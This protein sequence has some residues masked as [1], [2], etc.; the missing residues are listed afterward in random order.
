MLYFILFL[1]G[2]GIGSFLNVVT[3]RYNEDGW[4]AGRHLGG[5][6]RC[7]HCGKTLA[8]YEL[9]PLLSFIIQGAKCRSCGAPLSWQYPLVELL[10]ALIFVF[11]PYQLAILGPSLIW[12]LVF[13]SLLT[14]AVI[15]FR[16]YMVP[17]EVTAFL[18]VLGI[19]WTAFFAGG[20]FIGEHAEFFGLQGNVW[21]NHIFAAFLGAALIALIFFGTKGKAIGFGDVKLFG[22]LGLLFG[23]PDIVLVFFLSFIVG[24]LFSVPLLIRRLKGMKDFVPFAPFI[25]V[26][27]LIIF[28]AGDV[29]MNWYF[30]LLGLS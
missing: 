22:A 3:L 4:V 14:I 13:V 8:W 24:A 21:Q 29:I 17:D 23:W 1:L 9:I 11:V 15:D 20:S 27:S 10:T 19:V 26:A 7:P 6:S 2:L 25:A 16:K 12:I 5:R 30:S 18:F 28:F